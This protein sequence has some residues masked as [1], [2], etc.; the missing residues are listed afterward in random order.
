MSRYSYNSEI[1]GDGNSTRIRTPNEVLGIDRTGYIFGKDHEN[2]TL[3]EAQLECYDD[4]H[5][6]CEDTT[7]DK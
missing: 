1:C 7:R 4:V 6:M 5:R 3:P 2:F